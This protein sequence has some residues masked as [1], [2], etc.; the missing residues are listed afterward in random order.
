MSRRTRNRSQNK[1]DPVS[2]SGQPSSHCLLRTWLICA[3]LASLTI[4]AYWPAGSGGFV[5]LDDDA[6]VEFQPMVNQGLRPAAL[7]W[8]L[9][10]THSN[11]WH[12]LT[13]VSHML[14]CSMFGIT[15]GPMHW[16]NVGWH[17][18][19]TMLIFLLWQ[20]FSGATW[21][22]AIIAG[23]FA[24]HPAHVE[25]VA[26][27]AERKDVLSTFF[28]LL[29]LS[30]YVRHVRQRSAISYPTVALFF[31][32]ALLAKPMAVTFPLTLLL[33]D[34][35]P[36]GRWP[37]TGWRRLI[38]EKWPLFALALVHGAVTLAVQIST[39]ASHYGERLTFAARLGNAIVSCVRYVAK[40]VWP[41]PLA[42]HYDHPGWWSPWAIW[43]A[44]IVVVSVTWLTWWQRRSRPWLIFGWLWFVVTLLPV[45]GI[46]QVG[47]QAMADR[48]T[49]VPF[50]G[51]FT[52]G[53][54]ALGGL[55]VRFRGLRIPMTVAAILLF[56]LCA[57]RTRQQSAVWK[58]SITLYER[59]I[60]AGVD[61]ATIRYLLA[62]AFQATRYPEGAVASQLHRAIEIRPSYTN[63]YTQLAMLAL[64]HQDFAEA[65]RLVMETIRLEPRN[66]ALRKNLGVLLDLQGR[67]GE[68]EAQ[69]A[70]ALKLDPNYSDANHG[71]A[72]MYLKQ[73][74]LS[75]A[76][77]ELETVVRRSPWDYA[78]HCELGVVYLRLGRPDDARR[79][80]ARALWINPQYA[81]AQQNLELLAAPNP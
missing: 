69:F 17:V 37:A 36:L 58:D 32:L 42:P 5:N 38:V 24:L 45:I 75:A 79:C 7:T 18:L 23:L 60:A 50:I 66:P 80:F 74:R 6:Y 10:A 29:G 81:V 47:S 4:A 27:I 78:A 22:S 2:A 48:Y 26:W 52:A 67:A 30:A 11:N 14:D 76:L 73:E 20:S 54:W 68:A 16:E 19:N 64:N 9:T 49:Y 41:S 28:W 63:A 13:S 72:W 77:D 53:I 71:L 35:W 40:C 15:P 1:A 51:L 70:E 59:S 34:Y 61:N 12:P 57:V 33:L 39:G 25:S 3:L 55:T 44:T 31:V 46:V 43:G 8:A 21:R 65:G 56:S 62:V